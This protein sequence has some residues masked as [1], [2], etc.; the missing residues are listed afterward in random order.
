MITRYAG[1]DP[2]LNAFGYSVI[3]VDENH[4]LKGVHFDTIKTKERNIFKSFSIVNSLKQLKILDGV[5]FVGI[6]HY[7][8]G[9]VSNS[10]YE[11]GELGGIIRYFCAENG[12]NLVEIPP[13]ILKSFATNNGQAPKEVVLARTKR[14]LTERGI[15]MI[16]R[17]DDEADAFWTAYF[18]MCF[19]RIDDKLPIQRFQWDNL[20][21]A[22][23]KWEELCLQSESHP[24]IKF[25][26]VQQSQ[27]RRRKARS[28]RCGKLKM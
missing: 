8:F 20:F 3:E 26:L 6:E 15:D 16:P 13:A 12:V 14:F 10:L 4:Q 11:L 17:T 28:S 25:Y 23:S 22:K 1:L 7:N 2:S 5:H 9:G 27:Q 24:P 19:D 21:K 18:A